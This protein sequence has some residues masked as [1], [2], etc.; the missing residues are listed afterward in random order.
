MSK[1]VDYLDSIL[2]QI[3]IK[4]TIE[5]LT[6]LL[7]SSGSPAL[8]THVDFTRSNRLVAKDKSILLID[9]D[10]SNF[11]PRGMDFGRYFS[12]YKH[13]DSIFG[14]EGFPTD[15]EMRLFLE[16][17]RI[18]SGK[19]NSNYLD[20]ANNS[21]EQLIKESKLFALN[22]Y[23]MDTLFA[24]GMFMQNFQNEKAEYFLVGR[25]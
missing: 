20:E 18:E 22:L 12:N 14:D 3:E 6:P 17:Y 16:E 23:F 1:L 21:I 7:F 9:F 25:L 5:K 2:S 19:L 4:S 13:K 24:I 10:F 8:F 15:Q 11:F